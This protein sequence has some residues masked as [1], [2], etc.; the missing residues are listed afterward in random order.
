MYA[1]FFF[2]LDHVLNLNSVLIFI[3]YTKSLFE[4]QRGQDFEFSMRNIDAFFVA[5]ELTKPVS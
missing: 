4:V 3:F 1:A 2:S 5:I